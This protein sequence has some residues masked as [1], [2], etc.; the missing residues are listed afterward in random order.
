M[1]LQDRLH[2][3]FS[4][5]ENLPPAFGDELL[6]IERQAHGFGMLG[7]NERYRQRPLAPKALLC[8]EFLQVVLMR[9]HHQAASLSLTVADAS[10]GSR[11]FAARKR[12]TGTT[13]PSPA[14]W[15]ASL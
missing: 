4:Q 10:K 12:T 1:P 5:A 14:R 15:Y 9:A 3:S 6:G 13:T 11:R 8:R 2:G 7:D